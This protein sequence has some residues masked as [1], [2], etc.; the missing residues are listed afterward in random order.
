MTAENIAAAAM[1]RP[2]KSAVIGKLTEVQYRVKHA[3]ET[4]ELCDHADGAAV[5]LSDSADW[6]AGRVVDPTWLGD[7]LSG[8]LNVL[9][10]P[11]GLTLRGA[12]L[13]GPLDWRRL[14]LS[15]ALAL[16]ECVLDG[17]IPARLDQASGV[18]L[19]LTGCRLPGLS[20]RQ[21]R[22][23][24]DLV[25]DASIIAD[26]VTVAGAEIGGCL[27]ARKA[28]IGDAADAKAASGVALD[29][30]QMHIGAHLCLSPNFTAHGEVILTGANID[31][32]LI[33]TGSAFIGRDG[34]AINADTIHVGG[35]TMFDTGFKATGEV[36][37]V[38]AKLLN[39]ECP[40]GTFTNPDKDA[41][42]L[43]FAEITAN[44]MMNDQSSDTDDSSTAP[45]DPFTAVGAVRVF[46]AKIG[47]Q[48]FCSGGKFTNPGG[49]AL[50]CGH[51]DITGSVFLGGK[52]TAEGEVWME[53]TK[54]GGQLK[55][56]GG[57]FTNPGGTALS[58]G[59]ADITGSVFLG[60]EFTAEGE[61]SM[62]GTKIGGQLFCSGGTFTNSGGTA[63][64]GREMTVNG[65]FTWAGLATAPEGT[66]VL[67]RAGVGVL[68]DD[69]KSW[70]ASN[71]GQESPPV[72]NKLSLSGFTYG[73]LSN[74]AE[75]DPDKRLTWI[76]LQDGYNPQPYRQL[77]EVY[78]S[79]GH[80]RKARRILIAQ[81]HDRRRRGKLP[82]PGRFW[83]AFIGA[84]IG[85]GYRTWS[86][87]LVLPILYAV[88]VYV[89]G[90]AAHN[91]NMIPVRAGQAQTV[92]S[93]NCTAKYPCLSHWVYPVDYVV[94]ILN[95]RQAEYWQPDASTT[96]GHVTRN[97][98][99]AA[100]IL[101]WLTTTLL[102]A[103]FTGL[104]RKD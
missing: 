5:N 36:R 12:C 88:S 4:G 14:P 21:L 9:L 25:L 41:L 52:F 76:R 8:R 35:E 73:R 10:H 19:E 99:Y 100:T 29:G 74:D 54:I 37:L 22:L 58:C 33:C 65:T 77:A 80:E 3:A 90:E 97:W 40:G 103:A 20:A 23:R 95:L 46:G 42:V 30:D 68:H 56:S 6:D 13:P 93:A 84:T 104:V 16:R 69:Q 70:P 82:L 72:S 11:R 63:F 32:R 96:R 49:T 44:V 59:H 2:S 27:T 7:L 91:N 78:R 87:A 48:I 18:Q 102:V 75:L 50:S 1:P 67:A 64:N 86:V 45:F 62:E 92:T 31:G 61:V 38:G 57:K 47:G 39:L 55:C 51:A 83:S 53:G 15:V 17:D 60:D 101:G 81:R 43:E 26:M 85:Y 34:N 98:L 79:S 89:V 71:D 66:V 24:H 28:T 94:P